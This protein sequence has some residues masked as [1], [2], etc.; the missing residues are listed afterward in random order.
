MANVAV[1]GS[2]NMDLVMRAGQLPR[3]GETLQGEFAM[4]LGG[5]GFNQAVA[6]RRLGA[7]VSVVGRVGDD[8]FGRRFLA[9]LD[10]EGIDGRS[11]AI[12]ADAGTGVASIVVDADGENAILQA[13]RANR[14]LTAED[15]EQCPVQ[16]GGVAM[17]QIETSM[18]AAI[19]FA[20]R[21]RDAGVAT[22]LNPAP[23]AAVPDELIE[24]A[25]VIVPNL[26][27]ARTLTGIE[28]ESVDAAFAMAAELRR[29]GPR[30]AVVTLGGDGAVVVDERTT[31]RVP[32]FR[33]QAV[34][35]VGAG[36]T[37]CAALAVA[38]AE[39]RELADAVA[40]ACAAGALA[41][42]RHGAEPSLPYRH[43]VESLLETGVLA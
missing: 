29:R 28:G 25:D 35:T 6:A 36:D 19:A 40:F 20:R 18:A 33:V 17:L 12:D 30:T 3:A 5:K 38:L 26:I 15:V 34:D 10:R 21:A 37:F 22:L 42:T 1:L 16:A 7:E 9:A 39:G 32:A 11:V 31:R 23:A 27:E 8:E 14:N 2:F 43:E 13:P 24:L 41:T 4:H